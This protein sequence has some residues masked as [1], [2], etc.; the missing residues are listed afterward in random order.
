MRTALKNALTIRVSGWWFALACLLLVCVMTVMKLKVDDIEG[1]ADSNIAS[2]G[3][4]TPYHHA[5]Q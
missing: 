5:I 4:P 2:L 1:I 3:Q